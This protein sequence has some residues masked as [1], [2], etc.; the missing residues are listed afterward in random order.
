MKDSILK[1][2][3]REF[4]LNNLGKIDLKKLLH[5]RRDLDSD[6]IEKIFQ[7][8]ISKEYIWY[9]QQVSETLIAKYAK[10]DTDWQ[11][12]G[13][14]QKLSP[15]FITCHRFSINFSCFD[16]DK[17]SVDELILVEYVIFPYKA[18]LNRSFTEKLKLYNHR[19]LGV[20]GQAF[21][22]NDQFIPAFD[23]TRL[24]PKDITFAQFKPYLLC[25][26][27]LSYVHPFVLKYDNI[28]ELLAE[29]CFFVTKHH[30]DILLSSDKLDITVGEWDA[31]MLLLM[32]QS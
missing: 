4:I 14:H 27:L 30:L 12:I 20:R 6:V 13:L 11:F 18:F 17:Y 28:I 10:D 9:T 21:R 1:E 23:F 3:S 5:Y 19:K 24:A 22:S 25:N 29:D 31:L 16:Y 8:D 7:S 26:R 2:C 32:F 15:E